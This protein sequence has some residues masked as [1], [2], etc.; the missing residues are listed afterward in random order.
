MSSRMDVRRFR[1]N[2]T[3]AI[4]KLE[5]WVHPF[6]STDRGLMIRD[7]PISKGLSR[8]DY[9]N[10]NAKVYCA[11]PKTWTPAINFELNCNK[12]WINYR[13]NRTQTRSAAALKTGL[14]MP[15]E[16]ISSNDVTTNRLVFI[17]SGHK[18]N[19]INCLVLCF[20]PLMQTLL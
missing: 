2:Q 10:A 5:D 15:Q 11:N 16:E 6:T 20:V 9:S 14:V 13:E 7:Q 8:E 3:K 19:L 18:R 12:L 4:R 17:E 1:N